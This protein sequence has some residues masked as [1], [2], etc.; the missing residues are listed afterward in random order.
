MPLQIPLS[1]IGDPDA[2]KA[3]VAAFRQAKLDHHN[4]VRLPAPREHD[5]VEACVRRVPHGEADDY[6]IEDYAIAWAKSNG[7]GWHDKGRYSLKSRL[8]LVWRLRRCINNA[9]AGQGH[10]LHD[11]DCVTKP[12][13]LAQPAFDHRPK[14]KAQVGEI[15]LD[16]E[17]LGKIDSLRESIWIEPIGDQRAIFPH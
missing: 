6:V 15:L 7:R 12:S 5:L 14:T 4:T 16:H 17:R 1:Q 11:A 9:A 10:Q 3:H 8:G 13:L 2:F